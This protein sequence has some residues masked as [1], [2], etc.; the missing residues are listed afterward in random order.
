MKIKINTTIAIIT[1]KGN[2][3]F[4][5]F[6]I[7]MTL[8]LLFNLGV[9]I[10]PIFCG[11]NDPLLQLREQWTDGANTF[12]LAPG[13][14]IGYKRNHATISELEKHGYIVLSVEKYNENPNKWKKTN[15]KFIIIIEGSELVR[16]RGG[17]RCL[18]MPLRRETING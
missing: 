7:I 18:T 3:C 14:I 4:N 2:I 10:N 13:K 5:S 11:G 15:K 1:L 9:K 16:G 17:M 8:E 12:A 6:N